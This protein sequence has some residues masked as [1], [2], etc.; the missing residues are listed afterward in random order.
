MI[1]ETAE[2]NEYDD[3]GEDPEALFEKLYVDP[4]GFTF[5]YVSDV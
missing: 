4:V 5:P 1:T 3:V 2:E